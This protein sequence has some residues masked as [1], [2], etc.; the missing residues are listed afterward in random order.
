[1]GIR[2]VSMRASYNTQRLFQYAIQYVTV[3]FHNDLKPWDLSF[4]VHQSIWNFASELCLQA[5]FQNVKVMQILKREISW[6]QN[7]LGL[8]IIPAPISKAIPS[9]GL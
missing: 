1:M 5:I 6:Y 9:K 7:L 8:C 2:E 3:R 4:R